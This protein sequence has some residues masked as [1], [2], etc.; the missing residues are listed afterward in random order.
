[1]LPEKFN[2]VIASPCDYER[3][4]AEIYYDGRYVAQVS[5]ER[6]QG[7]FDIE[8]PGPCLVEYRVLRKVDSAG[9]IQA[10]EAACKLLK[11]ER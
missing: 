11:G 5:Q 6:D 9:F 7:L 8:T 2:I 4:V 1:M 10:V 3:L